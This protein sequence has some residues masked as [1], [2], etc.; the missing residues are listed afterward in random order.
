MSESPTV[1]RKIKFD[2]IKSNFFR[3]ARADGAWC[4]VNGFSDITLAFYSERSA[5]PRQ[6]VFA[7]TDQHGLGEEILAERIGRDSVVREVEICVSM[8]LDV[9]RS[10]CVLIEKQIQAVETAK[11]AAARKP[12]EGK[13]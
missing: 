4:G 2:Y 7:V 11:M 5:I 8:T 1:P 3:T 9:A 10:L 12:D 13:S 6:M